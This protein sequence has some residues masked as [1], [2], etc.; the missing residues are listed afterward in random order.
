MYKS[1][2]Q[3]EIMNYEGGAPLARRAMSGGQSYITQDIIEIAKHAS[4][5]SS[6]VKLSFNNLTFEVEEIL[7][8]EQI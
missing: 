6:A 7:S 1:D 4:K 2:S 5:K 3:L 8:K